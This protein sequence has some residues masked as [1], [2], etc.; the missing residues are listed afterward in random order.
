MVDGAVFFNINL[1][2]SHRVFPSVFSRETVIFSD[3]AGFIP[4]G[5]T[6]KK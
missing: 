3:R 5:V 6:G 1:V 2:K 4:R